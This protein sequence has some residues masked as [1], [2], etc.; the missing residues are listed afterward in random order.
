MSVAPA[1]ANAVRMLTLSTV[2]CSGE[3]VEGLA[4]APGLSQCQQLQSIHITMPIVYHSN[5]VANNSAIWTSCMS[6]ISAAAPTVTS[7]RIDVTSGLELLRTRKSTAASYFSQLNWDEFNRAIEHLPG[8]NRIELW[9]GERPWNIAARE[10]V[11]PRLSSKARQALQVRGKG[12]NASE[13]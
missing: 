3:V 11:E 4:L 7:L 2:M 13:P 8:L 9:L 10:V 6:L 12:S 5:A 1:S